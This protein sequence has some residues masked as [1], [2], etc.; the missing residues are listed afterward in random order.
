MKIIAGLSVLI[1]A[2]SMLADTTQTNKS[3]C[4]KSPAAFAGNSYNSKDQKFHGKID[5][6][7][8]FAHDSENTAKNFIGLSNANIFVGRSLGAN[9]KVQLNTQYGPVNIVDPANSVDHNFKVTEAFVTYVNDAKNTQFKAGK[10]FSSFG[11]FDPYR[12]DKSLMEERLS[13]LNNNAAEATYIINPDSYVKV[14]A[15]KPSAAN[16]KDYYGA[17]LGYAFSKDAVKVIADISMLNDAREIFSTTQPVTL[18]KDNVYQG[19]VA[20]IYGPLTVTG[21]LLRAP[22]LIDGQTETPAMKGI[23]IVYDTEFS[24]HKAMLIGEYEKT[25]HLDQLLNANKRV[26][27]FVKTPIDSKLSL[28]T[29]VSEKSFQANARKLR[30]TSVGIEAN[31]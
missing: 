14:W 18:A 20:V 31:I 30:T 13:N 5:L 9:T 3:E 28:V 27:F 15:V 7:K 10:F 23:S 16:I 22:K 26:A 6:Y 21:K 12:A 19:Q 17:K 8:T 1:A 24:G 4:S 2:T 11:S 25:S 29:G